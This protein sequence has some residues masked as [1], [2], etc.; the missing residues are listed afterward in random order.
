MSLGSEMRLRS[1]LSIHPSVDAVS[2]SLQSPFPEA[3]SSC[4][5]PKPSAVAAGGKRKPVTSEEDESDDYE[6]DTSSDE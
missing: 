2:I 3:D 4:S 6:T 5:P 1:D